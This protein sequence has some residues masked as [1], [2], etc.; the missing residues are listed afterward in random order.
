MEYGG[1]FWGE[2]MKEFRRDEWL[3]WRLPLWS[4]TYQ[5]KEKEMAIGYFQR[6]NSSWVLNTRKFQCWVLWEGR[7][8]PG[9]T[10]FSPSSFH[11][12]LFWSCLR[13]LHKHLNY[14][15]FPY[16]LTPVTIF[17]H[18]ITVVLKVWS[19]AVAIP[20]SARNLL[21]VEIVWPHCRPT[22][23]GSLAGGG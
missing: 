10:A 23:S 6:R 19:L 5:S 15:L 22:K 11:K 7:L 8:V 1:S 13:L 9:S 18:S 21:A 17:H 2:E 16:P 4:L 3:Y 14:H 20:T 12:Q